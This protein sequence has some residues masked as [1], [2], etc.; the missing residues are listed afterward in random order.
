LQEKVY[1]S[2][3][4]VGDTKMSHLYPQDVLNATKISGMPPYRLDL[5]VG[6]FI[7]LLRNMNKLSGCAVLTVLHLLPNVIHAEI[8]SGT[9]KGKQV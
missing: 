4:S 7:M 6:M 9:A 1:T 5:K 3:D 8:Q 2:A